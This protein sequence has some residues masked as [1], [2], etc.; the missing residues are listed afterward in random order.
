MQVQLMHIRVCISLL[1]QFINF[2]LIILCHGHGIEFNRNQ[3]KKSES[4]MFFF[5]FYSFFVL[6]FQ[7][8]F[9]MSYKQVLAHSI[10]ATASTL[11]LSL[12]RVKNFLHF[13]RLLII[14]GEE[15]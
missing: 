15:L 1:R 5:F 3:S 14:L 7:K 6:F 10:L 11:T 13:F 8:L 4:E 9:L 2:F 12:T